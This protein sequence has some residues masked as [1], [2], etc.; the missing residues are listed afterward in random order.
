MKKNKQA[1]NKE[2]SQAHQLMIHG[3]LMIAQKKHPYDVKDML[4]AYIPPEERKQ[5]ADVNE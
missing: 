5:F 3:V 1:I 2:N 4:T